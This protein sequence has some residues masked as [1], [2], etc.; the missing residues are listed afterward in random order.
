MTYHYSDLFGFH[1]E[2]PNS[3]RVLSVGSDAKTVKSLG[4]GYL[5]GI[6]YMLPSKAIQG[7]LASV[8]AKHRPALD[9]CQGES[10]P[11]CIAA[12]L[13]RAGRG[14]MTYTQVRRGHRTAHWLTD[15]EGF[16]EQV[17]KDLTRMRNR[18]WKHNLIPLF[19]PN[20]TT[21][22]PILRK[23]GFAVAKQIEGLRAFDYSGS[24]RE[25]MKYLGTTTPV[26]L[27]YKGP[28]DIHK[29]KAFLNEGGNISLPYV[30]YI[31]DDWHGYPVVDGDA[32]DVRLPEVDGH[33]VV[34]ALELKSTPGSDF[35]IRR[36]F[37]I[38]WQ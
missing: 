7:F 32:H 11:A 23:H 4:A 33:G 12:C 37:A 21:G 14:G 13:N 24:L 28:Q 10:T 29:C 20:G 3:G 34:V 25:A 31:R 15:P 8:Q 27:S 26:T 18:A 17:K 9:L 30:G 5:Q 22:C 38:N 36:G 6:L 35:A 2:R 1:Y 16:L 19:R